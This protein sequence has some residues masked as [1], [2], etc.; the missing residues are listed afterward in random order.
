MT[1][2]QFSDQ[3]KPVIESALERVLDQQAEG[4]AETLQEAMRYAVLGGG[5]R[6]RPLLALAT[7]RAACGEPER[8]LPAACATE[9]IHCFSLVHDDLPCMD[10]DDLR[11]GKPTCH[12]KFGE[13]TA[14]LAG[15][16]L[17]ALAFQCALEFD[18][19]W[20]GDA[21]RRILHTLT[22]AVGIRGMVAGQ[23]GDMLL[24][25]QEP[26]LERVNWIHSRKT[27]ALISAAAE[28][29]AISGGADDE[30]AAAAARFGAEVGLAFQIR[31]DLLNELSPTDQIGKS[32]GSDRE[33]GKVTYPAAVGVE[34]A[35][36]LML[37]AV[38]RACLVA[39]SLEDDG[40]LTDIARSAADRSA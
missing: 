35:E 20:D 38:E 23:V 34:E 9:L 36:R 19:A 11:R 1:F 12:V 4:P 3:W 13:A 18:P 31:D 16:A 14:L 7:C 2:D 8:A 29:G 39:R 10:N 37:E 26:T 28:A 32:G 24:Q 27:G 22:R 25:G 33:R 17:L 21:A 30:R 5:K 6:F 15:D 40:L